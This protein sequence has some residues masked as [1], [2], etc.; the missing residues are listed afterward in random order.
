MEELIGLYLEKRNALIHELLHELKSAGYQ[1]NDYVD[2]VPTEVKTM[3]SGVKTPV[4]KKAPY[5]S[6]MVFCK[7]M[8]NHPDHPFVEYRNNPK[9]QSEMLGEEW[10]S[11]SSEDKKLW[12]DRA[13]EYNQISGRNV[14]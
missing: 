9:R 5:T 12:A 7:E 13:Q 2:K 3:I 4:V 11:M 14:K 10:R 1:S 6:F 8:R